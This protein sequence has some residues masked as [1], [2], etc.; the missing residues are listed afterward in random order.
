M[1]VPKHRHEV[2]ANGGPGR[3]RWCSLQQQARHADDVDRKA[4]SEQSS[5][6]RIPFSTNI[7]KASLALFMV[8]P[9]MDKANYI[10]PAC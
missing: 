9:A 10:R 3:R 8:L 6:R 4:D 5:P 7:V 1:V 2:D